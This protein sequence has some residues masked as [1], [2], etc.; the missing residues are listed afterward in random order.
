M[1]VVVHVELYEISLSLYAFA[2]A[3][4]WVLCKGFKNPHSHV[5]RHFVVLWWQSSP[6]SRRFATRV[7]PRFARFDTTTVV[8][9]RLRR[10]MRQSGTIIK[11]QCE[12]FHLKSVSVYTL[13]TVYGR[14]KGGLILSKVDLV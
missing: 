9:L 4:F 10:Y 3:F 5:G 8:E 6:L 14:E 11:N 13:S 12:Q 2:L 1:N 7:Q